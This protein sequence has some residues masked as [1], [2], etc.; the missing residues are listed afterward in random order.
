MSEMQQANEV[1]EGIENEMADE[2]IDGIMDGFMNEV[3][4][5]IM[6]EASDGRFAPARARSASRKALWTRQ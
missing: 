3:M 2:M 4:N 5:G 6:N 1:A